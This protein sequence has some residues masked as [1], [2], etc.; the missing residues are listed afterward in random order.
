MPHMMK[1]TQDANSFSVA[2]KQYTCDANGIVEVDDEH[3]G[4]AVAHG[5]R[6]ATSAEAVQSVRTAITTPAM[7][8]VMSRDQLEGFFAA[9]EIEVPAGSS[10]SG[11]R[12]RAIQI[13]DDEADARAAAANGQNDHPDPEPEAAKE[14][15]PEPVAAEEAEPP[16]PEPEA[17]PK[18]GKP[19]REKISKE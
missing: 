7:V 6:K 17:E 15:E 18:P 12:G 4:H 3:F 1:S 8:M 9:R 2:G 11:M 10:T 19:A 5:F 16:P 14:P 13:V